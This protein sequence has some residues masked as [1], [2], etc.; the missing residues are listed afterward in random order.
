MIMNDNNKYINL[1]IENALGMV[2]QYLNEV[3]QLKTQNKILNDLV[4]EK[5]QVIN[6]LQVSNDEITRMQASN[7]SME[8]KYVN[9]K[10]KASHVDNLLNQVN[11]MK[12]KIQEKDKKIAELEALTSKINKRRN[13]SKDVAIG[14]S[15]ITPILPLN[16]SVASIETGSNDF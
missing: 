6:S 12:L 10:N 11:E 2:H 15:A 3:L 14:E 7:K 8:E 1:Y 9:M 13:K 4:L 5:D 16:M